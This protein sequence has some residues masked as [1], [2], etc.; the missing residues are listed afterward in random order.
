MY[1]RCTPGARLSQRKPQ[2]TPGFPFPALAPGI[3]A[4]HAA[5]ARPSPHAEPRTRGPR[6]RGHRAPRRPHRPSRPHPKG[7]HAR[8]RRTLSSARP[9]RARGHVA[10]DG[11]AVDRHAQGRARVGHGGMAGV[12][13]AAC[14]AVSDIIASRCSN[15]AG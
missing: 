7:R 2:Q 6:P 12:A 13:R 15:T 8:W 11:K 4:T 10:D 3:R 5:V 14:A 1:G 9:T